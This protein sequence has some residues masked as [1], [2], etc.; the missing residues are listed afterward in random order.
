V[1][2]GRLVSAAR[3]PRADGPADPGFAS[4]IIAWQRVHGRSGM[5]WQGTRDPYRIWLSEIMLQQTQVATARPYYVRWLARFP[6]LSAL[7]AAP[8]D[9]VMQAWAGLGYYARARHLHAC[10]R[11]LVA[12]HDGRFPGDVATLA[13]LPGIGRTTAAAIG[14]FCFGQRAAIL[15]GNVKRVLA[16][17][18]GVDLPPGAA[19]ERRLLAQAQALLP[20]AAADMPSYTQG[21][22]D[23]GA[24]VCV[25]RAPRCAACPVADSCAARRAGL[26]AV[27][28]RPRPVRQVPQ[29]SV[30]LLLV[31]AAGAVLLQRRP[32]QGIWGGLL[33]LPQFDSAT[34]LRRAAAPLAAARES[35]AGERRQ[36]PPAPRALPPRRHG[37]THF[38]LEFTPHVLTLARRPRARPVGAPSAAGARDPGSPP[39]WI[40]VPETELQDAALPA[41]LR[42]LMADLASG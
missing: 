29:R 14:A 8:L 24:L 2:A 26:T 9:D 19:L 33:A 12:H 5:P 38:T 34:A 11:Q 6:D 15:D 1:A 28:P 42:R 7:A 4:R 39:R 32:A 40:W 20:P 36:R 10:A 13:T 37:F 35:P 22:M 23:L 30:H 3:P 16:R 18:S 21:L 41:P 31:R 17:W 27:L 25:R